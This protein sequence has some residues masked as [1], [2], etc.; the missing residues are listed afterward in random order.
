MERNQESVGWWPRMEAAVEN[1]YFSVFLWDTVGLHMQWWWRHCYTVRSRMHFKLA[2]D[3]QTSCLK[4]TSVPLQTTWVLHTLHTCQVTFPTWHTA[5][6]V[7]CAVRWT[8]DPRSQREQAP[9]RS[10]PAVH[11]WYDHTV[12]ASSVRQMRLP[13]SFLLCQ[14]AWETFW[15]NSIRINRMPRA[16]NYLLPAL[17]AADILKATFYL[18]AYQ[19]QKMEREPNHLTSQQHHP[20]IHSMRLQ[21]QHDKAKDLMNRAERSPLHQQC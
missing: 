8:Q 19:I 12:T 14:P 6:P 2:L 18:S 5:P 21:I 7:R 4:S 15:R 16:E 13:S 3:L 1:P 11:P 20:A 9:H 10:S 17:K